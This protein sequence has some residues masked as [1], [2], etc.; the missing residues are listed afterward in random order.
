MSYRNLKRLNCTISLKKDSA[1]YGGDV[2]GKAF[3]QTTATAGCTGEQKLRVLFEVDKNADFDEIIF[4]VSKSDA[5]AMPLANASGAVTNGVAITADSPVTTIYG[6][7]KANGVDVATA[8]ENYG[9]AILEIDGIGEADYATN[10]YVRAVAVN[11]TTGEYV[12]STL[13]TASVSSAIAGN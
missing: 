5:S 8:T 2:F 3:K 1:V 6:T 7:V 4:W 9:W 11:K 13:A 10:L 12:Y